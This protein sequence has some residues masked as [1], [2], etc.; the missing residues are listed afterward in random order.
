VGLY[1]DELASFDERC[2]D[3]PVF[4]VGEKCSL[5]IE[6]QGTDSAFEGVR[7]DLD[8]TILEKEAESR[9]AYEGATDRLD[10]LGLLADE[11]EFPARPRL[12]RL[13]QRA[14]SFLT[15]R[16]VPARLTGALAS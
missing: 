15:D 2:D 14:R 1:V 8:A 11:R 7:I 6:G 3:R 12:E 10:E 4:G 5:A 16:T 9:P 13:D